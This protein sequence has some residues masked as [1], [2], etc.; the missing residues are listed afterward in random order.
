MIR[1]SP[2]PT[3]IS[4]SKVRMKAF[5]IFSTGKEGLLLK[6]GIRAR[7]KGREITPSLVA[8]NLLARHPCREFVLGD[9]QCIFRVQACKQI[10]RA[11]DEPRPSGLV[12]GAE[13]CAIVA[14]EILV[15][16]DVVLPVRIFLELLTPSRRKM[17]ESLLLISLAT[18]NKV[19]SL[20]EPVG[21]STLKSSP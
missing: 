16:K 13:A 20:P 10:E 18:S 3:I 11:G 2:T 6:L 5:A 21:H 15:E 1:W 12:A 17:L 8:G 4:M 14:V 7:A 9:L 19:N